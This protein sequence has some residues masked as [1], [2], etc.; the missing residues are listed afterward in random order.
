MTWTLHCPAETGYY[1]TRFE[2]SS[3]TPTP[4]WWDRANRVLVICGSGL[5]IPEAD[6]QA[7]GVEF[8]LVRL[9]EPA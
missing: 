5:A 1:W 2:F 4:A 3:A 7:R 9:E 6:F 8:W